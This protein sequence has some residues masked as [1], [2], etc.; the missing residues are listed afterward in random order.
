MQRKKTVDIETRFLY[1]AASLLAGDIKTCRFACNKI[2][3]DSQAEMDLTVDPCKGA[4]SCLAA[5][6]F[7]N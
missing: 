3:V 7:E 4:G 1:F 2:T 5:L 6:I